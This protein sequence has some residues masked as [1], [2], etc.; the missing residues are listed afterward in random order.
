MAYSEKHGDGYT[1]LSL[2]GAIT[3]HVVGYDGLTY[4]KA[5]IESTYNSYLTG[6]NKPLNH[7]GAIQ[8]ELWPNGSGDTVARPL[9]VPC[10]ELLIKPLV[11]GV[12]LLSR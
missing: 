5:G 8:R 6:M 9:I 12:A 7:L 2:Y 1:C 4:G 11:N 3:A 10:R